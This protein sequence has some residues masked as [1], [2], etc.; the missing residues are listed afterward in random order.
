MLKMDDQ[1]MGMTTGVGNAVS[2]TIGQGVMV[3]SQ[4]AIDLAAVA[5]SFLVAFTLRRTLPFFDPLQHDI[6]LYLGVWPVIFLWPIFF[7]REGLYPGLWLVGSQ[8]VKHIV[9]GTTLA[10]LTA[11]SATFVTKTGAQFSRPI[12]VGTWLA[13][14]ALIPLARLAL[15][16]VQHRLGMA[17]PS[18]I[19]I[20]EVDAAASVL[21]RLR[22]RRPTPI[23]PVGIFVEDT[24]NAGEGVEGVPILGS[25][26]DA[27]AW[28]R[29]HR[30]DVCVVR[31]T[32]SRET[33]QEALIEAQTR[34]FRK[35]LILP[36]VLSVS[37]IDTNVR[38]IDGILALEVQNNLVVPANRAAKRLLDLVF[39]LLLGVVAVP[40]GAAVSL[41]IL[42][43]S[44]RPIFYGHERIG[45]R[46]RPFV[47][48]KFRTMTQRADEVLETHFQGHPEAREE[49]LRNRKLANDPRLTSVGRLLRRLSLDELPQLW[50]VLAGEMSL[51]GP[52]P[53]VEEEVS[54]Y[55]PMIDLYYRVRPGLTGLWQVSGRSTLTYDRRVELDAYY[56]RNWSVWL[57]IVILARTAWVVIQGQGAV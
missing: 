30:V 35:V 47:A 31:R 36:E 50:N 4:V 49:W 3:G 42:L 51:V 20:G 2:S 32:P 45:R 56:V 33:P 53:I 27:A 41:A 1:V 8:H 54:K 26:D 46:G 55:G 6:N 12:I 11:V 52:R 13:T 37:T 48:W 57:D 17:G 22:R 23:V 25:V 43:P 38:D 29:G 34:A 9:A 44:G 18:A 16:R 40:V 39:S 21:R 15:K 10:S 7:W 5:A 14:L 28:A 24:A 19:L